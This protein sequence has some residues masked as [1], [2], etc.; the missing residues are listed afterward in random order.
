[1]RNSPRLGFS[2]KRRIASIAPS[3]T[4]LMPG[5][6]PCGLPPLLHFAAGWAGC[7]KPAPAA[8]LCPAMGPRHHGEVCVRVQ[9]IGDR[10]QVHD[11][12]AEALHRVAV[13][14]R[15]FRTARMWAAMVLPVGLTRIL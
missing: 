5:G 15:G 13:P 6:L 3:V 8:D 12:V 10:L 7:R 2:W 14:F 11:V 4:F 1:M 9:R